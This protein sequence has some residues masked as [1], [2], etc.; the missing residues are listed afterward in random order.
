MR[1]QGTSGARPPGPTGPGSLAPQSG[2]RGDGRRGRAVC[3]TSPPLPTTGSTTTNRA[4]RARCLARRSPTRPTTW[5]PRARLADATMEAAEPGIVAAPRRWSVRAA[6]RRRRRVSGS[7]PAVRAVVQ[8]RELEQPCRGDRPR[9]L[10]WLR[11]RQ[12]PAGSRTLGPCRTDD[13][14]R[15]ASCSIPSPLLAARLHREFADMSVTAAGMSH[16]R[17]RPP[18]QRC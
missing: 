8:R 10:A 6:P 9:R 3:S 1:A 17:G 5:P 16:R 12:R 15:R 18:R 7:R 14:C 4:R 13:D 2:D 11:P